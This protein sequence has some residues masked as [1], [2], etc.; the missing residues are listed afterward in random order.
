MQ[1][2]ADPLVEL[3]EHLLDTIDVVSIACCSFGVGEAVG[4]P[5]GDKYE[6]CLVERHAG[7]RDLRDDVTAPSPIGEHLLDPADRS[8]DAAK[9]LNEIVYRCSGS[10]IARLL[11]L[12]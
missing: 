3:H 12:Y 4:E 8:F 10:S 2:V 6:S 11:S 9:P 1:C 7:G 5:G